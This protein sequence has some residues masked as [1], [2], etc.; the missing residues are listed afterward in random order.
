MVQVTKRDYAVE[1][2]W[3]SWNWRSEGDFL[4]NGASFVQSGYAIRTMNRNDEIKA[5]PGTF[6]GRLTRFAG[7]L[8]CF[9]HKPC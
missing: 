2:V 1:S 3:K 5:K 7:A 6:V 8:N 4:E 9:K